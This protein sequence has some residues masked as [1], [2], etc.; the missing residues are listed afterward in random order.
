MKQVVFVASGYTLMIN[1]LNHSL[2]SCVTYV[3]YQSFITSE[4]CNVQETRCNPEDR[5]NWRLLLSFQWL[6]LERTWATLI[7]GPIYL[8]NSL[9][10][11]LK[12]LR[13]TVYPPTL[14]P[15]QVLFS[16][17]LFSHLRPSSPIHQTFPIAIERLSP[18][19]PTY[20]RRCDGCI[21]ALGIDVSSGERRLIRLQREVAQ[22]RSAVDAKLKEMAEKVRDDDKRPEKSS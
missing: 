8:C 1:L 3:D 13:Q 6:T 20:Y 10:T 2:I 12:V 9:L 22:L 16:I 5:T 11:E 18:C 14:L 4:N 7:F 17:F 21:S 19:F 15:S